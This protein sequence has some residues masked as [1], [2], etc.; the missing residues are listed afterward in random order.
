MSLTVKIRGDASHFEKTMKGIERQ[1]KT[2][3][4]GMAGAFVGV[5][6]GS[7][8]AAA[9]I[10]AAAAAAAAGYMKLVKIGESAEKDD[11]RLINVTKQMGIFGDEADEVAK[12][13]INFADQQE[14]ATG[15]DTVAMTQAKLM[16][17][18]ELAKTAGQMG[19]AF[20]RATMA[21]VDMAAAGFGSAEQNAVQLGKALNDPVKGINSLTR[22]G[23]T[24]TVEEKK[25]IAA[26]VES[27]RMLDAQKMILKAI[28]TQVGGTAAASASASEKIGQSF[29]QLIEEFAGPFAESF[30]KLPDL[31]ESVFPDL[32]SRAGRMG[33]VV[34]DAIKDSFNGQYEGMVRIG[35]AVGDA[36]FAGMGAAI[37]IGW[38]SIGEQIAEGM[39]NINPLRKLEM[40]KDSPKASEATRAGRNDYI[41]SV[42]GDVVAS[43]RDAANR[44]SEPVGVSPTAQR[45][46]NEG[47]RSDSPG[48]QGSE[49][50]EM[51][52]VLERIANAVD[53]PFPN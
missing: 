16:T 53:Q 19:G 11:K 28:E 41:E 50:G 7:A 38:V 39:E 40:F 30:A 37:K 45:L 31:L 44:I 51:L 20:D 10:T 48:Y 33:G 27:N 24:F 13:L 42:I 26:M 22:S 8:V 21:A 35:V 4:S 3:V 17:F 29:N 12:R 14:R 34:S 18:K 15:A 5:A 25:K 46:F 32:K 47:Y 43:I 49:I 9:A 6:K 36:I 2:T 1:T 52:Q 23:I